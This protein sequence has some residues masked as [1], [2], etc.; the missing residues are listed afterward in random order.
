MAK[1]KVGL[2]NVHRRLKS[3][4]GEQNGLQIDSNI[5]KGTICTIHIPLMRK[6]EVA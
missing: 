3:V 6:G 5:G 1:G 2:S 4:Y